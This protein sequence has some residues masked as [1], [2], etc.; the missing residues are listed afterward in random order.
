MSISQAES[1]S[2]CMRRHLHQLEPFTNGRGRSREDTA[3]IQALVILLEDLS[4]R[5]LKYR[6]SPPKSNQ[7]TWKLT[8]IEAEYLH[9][10]IL[11]CPFLG[12]KE[13]NDVAIILSQIDRQL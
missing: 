5:I 1:L 3:L 7:L 10:F 9:R 8:Y 11:Y 6:L 13:T 4:K 12:D 2:E